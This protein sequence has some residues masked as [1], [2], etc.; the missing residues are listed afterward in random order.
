MAADHG[1]PQIRLALPGIRRNALAAPVDHAEEIHGRDVVLGGGEFQLFDG[2]LGPARRARAVQ[3]QLAETVLRDFVAGPRGQAQ[4][5]RRARQIG[6]C[7]VAPGM[8]KSQP[9]PAFRMLLR[10]RGGDPALCRRRI[11]GHA[12]SQRQLMPQARLGLGRARLGGEAIPFQRLGVVLMHGGAMLEKPRQGSGTAPR[13]AARAVLVALARRG[14]NLARQSRRRRR[15]DEINQPQSHLRSDVT[16]RGGL[17]VPMHGVR[18]ALH[19]PAGRLVAV[20]EFMLGGGIAFGPQRP[21][22]RER[23]LGPGVRKALQD[24]GEPGP[25]VAPHAGGEGL[26]QFLEHRASRRPATARAWLR[27]PNAA[28]RR[29]DTRGWCAGP[30]RCRPGRSCRA[31]CG[32]SWRRRAA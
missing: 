5:M 17:T 29:R 10:R 28:R 13:A 16:L 2:C 31:S 14:R 26:S 4:P 3:Q 21:Q 25:G 19:H 7:V 12:Q 11:G 9:Q 22:F 8:Q 23:L 32:N 1:A 30:P 15:F 20:P 27:S 24:P 6:G 18:Q